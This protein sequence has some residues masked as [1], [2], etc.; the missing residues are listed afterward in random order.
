MYVYIHIHTY[1]HTHLSIIIDQQRGLTHNYIRRN[2]MCTC[3]SRSRR[4]KFG[5]NANSTL[6]YIVLKRCW[7][8]Q[9][10]PALCVYVYVCMNMCVYIYRFYPDPHRFEASL[11]GTELP[12][13]VCVCVYVHTYMY[14]YV[15][16]YIH[17]YNAFPP[18]SSTNSLTPN[19]HV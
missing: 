9:N 12:S 5:R 8:A 7:R 13:P 14:I 4:H 2:V 3:L 16:I 18:I 15:C 17:V 11:A 10:Y 1:I 19:V 6:I